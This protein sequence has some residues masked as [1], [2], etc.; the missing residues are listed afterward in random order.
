MGQDEKNA[1]GR[2]SD[3]EHPTS[4]AQTYA[5]AYPWSDVFS[6]ELSLRIY[7]AYDAQVLA[8]ERMLGSSGPVRTLARYRVLRCLL[9]SDQG[10][11]TQAE[12]MADLGVTSANITRLVDALEDSGLVSRQPHPTD[13]RVTYV[14]LT[15]AGRAAASTLAPA[16]IQFMD[17]MSRGFSEKEKAQFC[18]FLTR[19]QSNAGE[20]T[21]VRKRPD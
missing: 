21:E 20:S 9:F 13:R 4:L 17:Q 10:L 1:L 15:D 19:F 2:N 8:V 18:A 11:K 7:A 16:M 12:I 6:T 3:L 14:S 5:A